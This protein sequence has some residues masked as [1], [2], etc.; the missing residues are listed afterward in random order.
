MSAVRGARP[1]RNS[2]ILNF[3]NKL[4][5][6]KEPTLDEYAKVWTEWMNFS[7]TKSIKG[8]DN[9]NFSDYTQ[10]T[11]QTFDNFV[12]KNNKDREINC[13]MGDFQYHA[14]LGKHVEFNYIDYP[15]HLEGTLKGPDLHALII[16]APFSD[17]GCIHPDFEN[18]LR[19]CDVHNIPVCLD[20][21]YWGIAK[22]VHLDLNEFPCIKEVT[23]SLSKPFF[24]LENHRVGIRWTRDYSD[25][26]ISMLNEVKMANNYSMALGI[27]YMKNFGA[28]YN[29]NNYRDQY[30][31]ICQKE[32]L[33]WTDTVIFGLGDD[34]RHSEFNR[35]VSGNYRVCVSGWLSDC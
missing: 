25:D 12:L 34:I 22:H 15:H 8:L 5:N 26:G 28:D 14:C 6:L 13:L 27:E 33:V 4:Q 30:E 20:L 17:F 31:E 32:D 19:I 7:D 11:S 24:T 1:I 2:E 16:S 35:G 29:W 10:G 9:F 3:H 18:I 23:C 21:A